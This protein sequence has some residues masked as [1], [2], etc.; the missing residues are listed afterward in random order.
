[1]FRAG[2]GIYY[3]LVPV[4]VVSGLASQPPIFSSTTVQAD[5]A[6]FLGTRALTDGPLRV[7]DPSLPGQN[8]VA[9]ARDFQIPTCSSGTPP[10]SVS[11]R[12]SRR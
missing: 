6:D 4:P 9:F 12:G 8:R 1:M 5:Q 2:Y 3:S 10:C 7:N 11:C